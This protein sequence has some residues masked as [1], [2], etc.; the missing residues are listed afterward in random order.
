MVFS[1]SV[2]HSNHWF[3]EQWDKYN[4][5]FNTLTNNI[6]QKLEKLYFLLKWERHWYLIALQCF[7]N[8]HYPFAAMR[9]EQSAF[10]TRVA[11][12]FAM[13]IYE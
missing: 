9:A 10:H 7:N 11:I 2:V 1:V 6:T 12:H 13:E 8:M 4:T 3:I 5:F